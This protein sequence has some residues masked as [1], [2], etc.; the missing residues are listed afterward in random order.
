MIDIIRTCCYCHL[1]IVGY[2]LRKGDVQCHRNFSIC[3]DLLRKEIEKRDAEITQL[4]QQLQAANE[5][6]R[7]FVEGKKGE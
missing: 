4:E 3:F 7:M 5:S 1:P 2:K 6:L